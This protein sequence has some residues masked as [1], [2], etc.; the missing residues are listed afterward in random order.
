MGSE[1]VAILG[2]RGM[3]GTDLAA[4]CAKS[5]YAVRTYDL[6]EFDITDPEHIR[7]AIGQAD[8]VV[9]CAA[10]TNVDGAETHA[11]LAHRVNAEAVGNLGAIAGEMGK[12]V[13]HFSTD[14]V[15][16]GTL[17]RPYRECDVAN[18]INE[19]GRTKLAGERFL[20][21]TDCSHCIVRVEWTYGAHGNNFVAKVAERARSGQSLTM[22]E[23]QIGS[24]T[25]TTE[26]AAAA[27]RLIAERPEGLFHL[28]ASGYVSRYDMARFVLDRLELRTEIRP[29]QS[30]DF[31]ASAARP[32]N[33][34]FECG[35]IEELLK[36]P[37]APWEG[38]LE[39]FLRRS[40][41]EFS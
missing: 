36:E 16:D 2:G 10:Y 19:Y 5:G 22:V 25:A 13:L 35:K 37:L 24:P 21:G 20:G 26:V 8:I 28:A 29:C 6:P 39:D 1:V 40:C 17:D 32:L 34:R 14:F 27:C 11:E 4:M 7:N 12:W 38:P 18:P 3:L 9:N 23:D 33:S 15:F 31:P 41:N 30:T